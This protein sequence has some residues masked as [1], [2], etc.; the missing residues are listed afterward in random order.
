MSKWPMGYATGPQKLSI[1]DVRKLQDVTPEQAR[2][3]MKSILGDADFAELERRV[4]AS[5][6]EKERRQALAACYG[7]GQIKQGIVAGEYPP[8]D[9][10]AELD[11]I[12]V[13]G[14]VT[15]RFTQ[16][17]PPFKELPKAWKPA[18]PGEDPPF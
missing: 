5:M 9:V 14:T 18:V 12:G 17:E 11:R 7:A 2:G 13:R 8:P 10:L 15:G 1:D 4:L 16:S 3:V 6:T